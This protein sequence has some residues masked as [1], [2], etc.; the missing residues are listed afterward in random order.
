MF[1]STIKDA[2]FPL[3]QSAQDDTLLLD[4]KGNNFAKIVADDVPLEFYTKL[5]SILNGT[6]K[7]TLI[8]GDFFYN[9]DENIILVDNTPF[10]EILT[11]KEPDVFELS[12]LLIDRL[13]SNQGTDLLTDIPLS[14]AIV[15]ICLLACILSRLL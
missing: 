8:E 10:I 12:D 15:F 6:E 3:T 7:N 1:T 5:V 13:E 14:I 9:P 2:Y 11:D 4:K